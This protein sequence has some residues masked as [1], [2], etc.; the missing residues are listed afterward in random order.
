VQIV[1]ELNLEL[2]PG[3]F[4][5]ILGSNGVEQ[6]HPVEMPGRAAPR[7]ILAEAL[8][9]SDDI[10]RIFAEALRHLGMLQQ[11]RVRVRFNVIQTA[12]TEGI[13]PPLLAGRPADVARALAALAAVDLEGF[14][15]RSVTSLSGGEA[16][17][18]AFAA[19]IVQDPEIL[20]LDEPTNHLDLRDQVRIMGMIRE[21][22]LGSGHAAIAALH[23]VNCPPVLRSRVD[24]LRGGQWMATGPRKCWRQEPRAITAAPSKHSQVRRAKIL[25]PSGLVSSCWLATYKS[26][27][28]GS[29]L[30]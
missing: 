23:D 4:W 13:T 30:P 7:Q 10:S 15:D 25:S 1:T 12:L 5:G 26:S 2:E 3:S 6:D 17:R 20:L 24:A 18:L 29:E 22:V 21:R 9:G 27:P 16:R 11:H 8:L 28:L 14:A 19:L